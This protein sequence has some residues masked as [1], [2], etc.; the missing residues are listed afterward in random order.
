MAGKHIKE[1]DMI[2]PDGGKPTGADIAVN[3]D[4]PETVYG[5]EITTTLKE[6]DGISTRASTDF[7]DESRLARQQRQI[8]R[9]ASE[10]GG[11]YGAVTKENEIQ[12]GTEDIRSVNGRRKSEVLGYCASTFDGD[13][14]LAMKVVLNRQQLD[15]TAERQTVAIQS[16]IRE[17]QFV[18]VDLDKSREYVVTHEMGHALEGSLIAKMAEERKIDV[19]PNW[20]RLQKEVYNDVYRI[21]SKRMDLGKEDVFLSSY[22]RTNYA[23]WFA[24]TFTNLKLSSD[25]KPIAKALGEYLE[26]KGK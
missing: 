25:P 18:P 23:E 6:E 16:G 10:Y 12:F 2:R 4:D 5:T 7:E 11:I 17:R 21:A 3:W 20:N 19:G 1:K 22:A 14:K 26:E 15:K 9:L 24:E 13:G 8:H